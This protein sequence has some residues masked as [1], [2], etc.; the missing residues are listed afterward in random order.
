MT[1]AYDVKIKEE[2]GKLV[3][4]HMVHP[5]KNI[6]LFLRLYN[7]EDGVE[8]YDLHSGKPGK[9]IQGNFRRNADTFSTPLLRGA[10][11]WDI[12]LSWVCI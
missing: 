6:L 7:L 11:A 1:K 2:T 9:E 8:I 5:E 4:S 12:L 10:P 3:S